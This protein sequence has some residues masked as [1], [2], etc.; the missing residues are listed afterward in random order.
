MIQMQDY[1]DDSLPGDIIG[2]EGAGIGPSLMLL[3]VELPQFARPKGCFSTCF[4]RS[5]C[6]QLGR[7]PPGPSGLQTMPLV[8]LCCLQ[9]K[10]LDEL[11]GHTTGQL[12][13]IGPAT[14]YAIGGEET[15]FSRYF[16]GFSR[17]TYHFFPQTGVCTFWPVYIPP[18]RI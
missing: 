17:K 3:P 14:S 1:H 6:K 18:R 2:A 12:R 16:T 10:E 5:I 15:T 9:Y 13:Y 8:V 7:T 11:S 4:V